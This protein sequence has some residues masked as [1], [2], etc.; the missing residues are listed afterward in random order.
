LRERVRAQ[1]DATLARPEIAPLFGPAAWAEQ[2]VVGEVDGVRIVG[3]VDRMAVV[4]D[5][6]WICDFKTGR[7]PAPGAPMP[8]AY[9]R[10]LR[11]YARV[12][13]PLFPELTIR[14]RLVW[15]ETGEVQLWVPAE[16]RG[17]VD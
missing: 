17:E 15:T 1:V 3:T 14:P 13:R 4:G 16:E 7:P 6:L 8:A 9:A 12:L 10:Q 5:E 2:P 11:D